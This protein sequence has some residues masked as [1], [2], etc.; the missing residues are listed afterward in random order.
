MITFLAFLG[1]IFLLLICSWIYQEYIKPGLKKPTPTIP[2]SNYEVLFGG[3]YYGA[4]I[5]DDDRQTWMLIFMPNGRV[6][7][8]ALDEEQEQMSAVGLITAFY[9]QA[10]NV[11]FIWPQGIVSDY[12]A[13][14]RRVIMTFER[15]NKRLR[16][17]GS[18]NGDRYN[19]ELTITS[20]NSGDA[21]KVPANFKFIKCD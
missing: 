2:V 8:C 13:I 3:V 4:A 16:I 18:I 20:N 12:A 10:T 5:D 9:A 11:N 19:A 21:F 17:A 14:G 1:L 15:N 6:A 7:H